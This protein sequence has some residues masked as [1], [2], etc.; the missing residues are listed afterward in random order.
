[1]S[2]HHS[3]KISHPATE[4]GEREGRWRTAWRHGARF[5]LGAGVLL[6]PWAFGGVKLPVQVTLAFMLLFS[7]LCWLLAFFSKGREHPLSWTIAPLLVGL[8]LGLMQCLPLGPGMAGWLS[9]HAMDL[10][11]RLVVEPKAE[12]VRVSQESPASPNSARETITEVFEAE[13]P[14]NQRFPLSLRVDSTRHQVAMLVMAIVAYFL[15]S[16]LLISDRIAWWAALLVL[17]NGSLYSLFGIL[18]SLTWRGHFYWIGPSTSAGSPFAA[19]VNRNNAA[20]YLCI[21]F[22]AGI[23]LLAW[24]SRQLAESQRRDREPP[25]RKRTANVIARMM[26][27]INLSQLDPLAATLLALTAMVVAG[28]ISSMSRGAMLATGVSLLVGLGASMAVRRVWQPAGMGAALVLG[29]GLVAWVGRLD[30]VSERFATLSQDE[31]LMA[32]GRVANWQESLRSVADFW[33]VGAGL[34]T[35]QDIY[36]LYQNRFSPVWFYHAENQFLQALVEGGVPALLALLAQI[37]WLGYLAVWLSRRGGVDYAFGI[38][39]LTCLVGQ[40]VAGSFDFGL[41]HPANFLLMSAVC[42][43]LAG[44][45]AARQLQRTSRHSRIR[46]AWL[47]PAP[48]LGAVLLMGLLWA[49]Q[50]L[51]GEVVCERVLDEVEVAVAPEQTSVPELE[52]YVEK[53]KPVASE[54]PDHFDVQYLLGRT[55]LQLFRHR[56]LAELRG[57]EPNVPIDDLWEATSPTEIHRQIY[58]WQNAEPADSESFRRLRTSP[59]VTQTLPAALDQFRR[60]R[61]ACPILPLPHLRLAQLAWVEDP[62]MQRENVYLAELPQIA[63]SNTEVLIDVGELFWNA[64]RSD[65]AISAWKQAMELTETAVPEVFRVV[66]NLVPTDVVLNEILPPSPRLLIAIA[67]TR[68]DGDS[69]RALLFERAS[70]ICSARLADYESKKMLERNAE[71]TDSDDLDLPVIV[72][73]VIET[74]PETDPAYLNYYLARIAQLSGDRD[75]ALKHYGAAVSMRRREFEWRLAYASLL[76]EAEKWEESMEEIAWCL[77]RDPSHPECLRLA[78]AAKRR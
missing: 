56:R 11:Q 46:Y 5:F 51:R 3:G 78:E 60:A 57:A 31:T 1:M 6:A 48:V 36:L 39:G 28:I 72:E 77:R 71:A 38:G 59:A 58:A 25:P 52:S 69:W 61:L 65:R 50:H 35:Y 34:G 62:V 68:R 54:Y 64:G 26:P 21:C 75:T 14:A 47:S 16:Q 18:Q 41:Y 4:G 22:A 55:Y 10:Q 7:L 20:G 19:Y 43:S 73:P 40:V 29:I 13:P 8:T 24:R 37:G 12:A 66:R 23:M 53:L 15:A 42:G 9:P 27:Q 44:R 30:M 33:R 45:A 67:E 63:P 76:L 2:E 74:D 17:V 49:G 70:E 32:D